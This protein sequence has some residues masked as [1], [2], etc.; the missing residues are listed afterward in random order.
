[1]ANY[2]KGFDVMDAICQTYLASFKLDSI[3][4]DTHFLIR[5][6]KENF[7][8]TAPFRFFEALD[9]Y[10]ILAQKELHLGLLTGQNSELMRV[11]R[12]SFHFAIASLNC[13]DYIS[14]KIS[15]DP[16]LFQNDGAKFANLLIGALNERAYHSLTTLPLL[17]PSIEKGN[18]RLGRF[19][20]LPAE[21]AAHTLLWKYYIMMELKFLPEKHPMY[22][23]ALDEYVEQCLHAGASTATVY[24]S[25]PRGNSDATHKDNTKKLLPRKC[26][27]LDGYFDF[28]ELELENADRHKELIR[29]LASR[30]TNTQIPGTTS[31]Q[32]NST[33]ETNINITSKSETQEEQHSAPKDTL[34]PEQQKA[35]VPTANN[36]K[37][38]T[39]QSQT[40][41]I[42]KIAPSNGENIQSKRVQ[43]VTTR[44]EV[45]LILGE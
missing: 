16:T 20:S 33:N 17:I 14:W 30:N 39:D 18:F 23:Q 11:I 34:V 6:R 42:S 27:C 22:R 9:S 41:T 32:S 19:L 7:A 31:T 15:N 8:D 35:P 24:D 10:N 1:M 25:S 43:Q 3:Q 38:L 2:C 12:K 28:W 4:Y 21:S 13:E 44:R 40:T 5:F 37:A 45:V 26:A 29:N 36:T